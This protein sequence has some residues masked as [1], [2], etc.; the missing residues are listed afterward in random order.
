MFNKKSKNTY[1]MN[2]PRTE[3]E[4][5]TRLLKYIS[6]INFLKYILAQ[7]TATRYIKWSG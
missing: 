5:H 1:P 6:E 3:V 4:T 7:A 2:S